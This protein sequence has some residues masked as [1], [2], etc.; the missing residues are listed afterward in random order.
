MKSLE[1]QVRDKKYWRIGWAI[2]HM[3]WMEKVIWVLTGKHK[4]M[5]HTYWENESREEYLKTVDEACGEL[6]ATVDRQKELKE[7]RKRAI[8]A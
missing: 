6:Q 8:Y 5:T 4:Y 3:S 1:D 2:M 7:W